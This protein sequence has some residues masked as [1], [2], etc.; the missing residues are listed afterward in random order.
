VTVVWFYNRK[1]PKDGAEVISLNCFAAPPYRIKTLI[2]IFE[3]PLTIFNSRHFIATQLQK[4]NA[5][6][7]FPCY[8]E[9]KFKATFSLTL[10]HG[11][12]YHSIS[13]MDLVSQ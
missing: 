2:K 10:K 9:P 8:D 11:S 13:N 1:L 12:D 4:I 6:T 7:V 5:R 3:I